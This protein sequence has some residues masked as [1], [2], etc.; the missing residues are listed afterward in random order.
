MTKE[1]AKYYLP[2]VQAMVDGKAIQI[3]NGDGWIDINDP[4]FG[5]NFEKYRIKPEEEYVPFDTVE[6]L[7]DCW[8]KKKFNG[9]APYNTEL[10]MPLIWVKGK[11]TQA[12]YLIAEY[13]STSVNF[14]RLI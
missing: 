8:N 3:F 5:S 11:G 14:E 4:N 10:E 1:N 13:W 2:L 6:E 7:I 12:K 9:K